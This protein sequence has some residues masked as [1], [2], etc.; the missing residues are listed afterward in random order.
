[1]YTANRW[2]LFFEGEWKA[3]EVHGEEVNTLTSKCCEW[4]MV[5]TAEFTPGLYRNCFFQALLFL[6]TCVALQQMWC[7][8]TFLRAGI[9]SRLSCSVQPPLLTNWSLS[10]WL[11]VRRVLHCGAPKS[12]LA[13]VVSSAG[14]LHFCCQSYSSVQNMSNPRKTH[15]VRLGIARFPSLSFQMSV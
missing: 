15:A 12:C 9:S 13:I 1:M 2:T 4:Q 5:A 8:T 7:C 11:N 6:M 10:L 3:P 14:F